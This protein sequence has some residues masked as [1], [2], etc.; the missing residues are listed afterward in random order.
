MSI[1]GQLESN[2]LCET[3]GLFKGVKVMTFKERLRNHPG[4]EE[5][6]ET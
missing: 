1:V 3:P 2:E 6:K 4:L 5:T